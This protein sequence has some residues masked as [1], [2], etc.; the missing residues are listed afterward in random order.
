MTLLRMFVVVVVFGI[1]AF[2]KGFFDIGYPELFA[3]TGFEL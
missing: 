1:P 3:Q 2:G